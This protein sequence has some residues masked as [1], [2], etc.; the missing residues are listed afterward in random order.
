LRAGLKALLE[1]HAQFSVI[2]EA[3][4]ESEALRIC[5]IESPDLVLIDFSVPELNGLA[6]SAHIRSEHARI[7][8]V[9]LSDDDR[10]EMVIRAFR[11]GVSACVWKG[12]SASNLLEV[13]ETVSK[14]GSYLTLELYQQ[15]LQSLE[16]RRAELDDRNP[17]LGR[18]SARELEVL[19][20]V[21]SGQCTKD[22]AV[23]LGLS[24]ETVRS[25]RKTMVKK[26]G[27]SN[28]ALLTAFAI[29]NGVVDGANRKNVPDYPAL[30]AI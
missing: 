23:T 30:A 9:A 27:F 12:V 25:Y 28:L 15:L 10:E 19:R 24:F 1:R 20:L 2:G 5:R 11:S 4:S 8:V 26:L 22:V 7:K 16:S 14:G 17:K 6:A 3:T 18:L 21:A 29:A 13:M